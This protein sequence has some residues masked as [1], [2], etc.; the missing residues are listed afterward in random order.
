MA[1][2]PAKKQSEYPTFVARLWLE[3]GARD[4]L[5]WRGRIKHVQGDREAYFN[6]FEELRAFLQEISGVPA[7]ID[8]NGNNDAPTIKG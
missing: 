7:P 6:S 1:S 5:V 4:A 2:H 3:Q 8:K